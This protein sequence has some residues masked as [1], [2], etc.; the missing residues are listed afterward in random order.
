MKWVKR[1]LLLLSSLLLAGI[2][3]LAGAVMFLQEANYKQILAWGAEQFLDSQLIINGPLKLDISRNLALAAGEILF[4]ANDDSYRLAIGKLYINFRLGSYL[5]TRSFVFNNLE[6]KDISL[7]VKETPGD[8]DFDFED[9]QIP[10]VVISQ[11][12]FGNLQFA[13]QEL[14][15]GTL[16]TFSLDALELKELG[17]KQPVSLRARGL[18]EGRPFELEGAFD[19]VAQVLARQDPVNAEMALSSEYINI[20]VQGTIDEPLEGRGLDLKVEGDILQLR[21]IIEIVWDEIPI[22][23]NVRSSFVVRGDYTAPQLEEIDLHIQREGEVDLKVSGSVADVIHGEG[24]DLQVEGSSSNPEVLSWLLFEQHDRMQTL[25]LSGKLQ[26]NVE[27]LSLLDLDATAETT[28]GVKLQVIGN[29]QL[30][31][32]GYTLTKNDAG[33]TVK[34]SIP[35]TKAA[36]ILD[37]EDLPELGPIS[38][39][40]ALAV[41]RDALGIYR[42]DLNVGSPKQNQ[43]LLKGDVGYLPLVQALDLPELN[44]QTDIRVANLASLG[45]QLG[46]ELPALGPAR[47]RGTLVTHAAKMQLQNAQ[48]KIA[49]EGQLTLNATGLLAVNLRDPGVD[50]LTVAMDVG[51]HAPELARL[52]K[53]FNVELP[54]LGP[55]SLRSKL[56]TEGPELVLQGTRLIVGTERQTI[57]HAT[58][59]L[60]TQLR[61]PSQYR[62]AMDVQ[63]QSNEISQLAKTFDYSLPELGPTRITGW[64]ESKESELHFEDV[65]ILVGA[66][67]QPDL[68]ANGGLITRLKKHATTINV[69]YEVVV[70]PLIAAFT[71]LQPN[72]LGRL[73]GNAVIA[74]LD[75]EWGIENFSIESTNTDLYQLQLSGGYDD[76]E[77]YDKGQLNSSLIVDNPRRLGE[78]FGLN[79]PVLGAFHQQGELNFKN[80]RMQYSG[81]TSLGRTNSVTK[82]LGYAN[83]GKPTFEGSVNIPV[84]HLA[85]FGFGSEVTPVV[86]LPDKQEP[87]SPYVFSR[88]EFDINFLN[89]F[90]FDLAVAIDEV[91]SGELTIDSING[92][93]K[94]H[95]GHLSAPLNLGFEGGRADINLDIKATPEPEFQFSMIADDL[96]LGP[97]MSQFQEQV[98]INGYTNINF[99]LKTK[100]RSPHKLASNLGGE[101]SL[102]LENARIPSRYVKLLS[103]DVFGW[104]LSATTRDK[105][106]NL[107]CVLM[108]F[109]VIQGEVKSAVIVADGPRLSIGGQINL[110]LGEET[111]DI[112]II[113]RQ[114]RRMFTS[115]SSVSISGPMRDPKVQAIPARAAAQQVGSFA[116]LGTGLFIP[117]AVVSSIWSRLGDNDQIGDG[118]DTLIKVGEEVL[119]I[120]KE[121]DAK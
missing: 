65:T 32:E 47:L 68:R 120:V 34:F 63:L 69:N 39:S 66:E 80:D 60:G 89:D 61:D 24:L 77:T 76:L 86:S 5:Q 67:K 57:L 88:D 22:L 96:M 99:E 17:E 3:L 53:Y 26:G 87:E 19:S 107:N 109:D 7:E 48:L 85:D 119:E 25:H 98:P 41:S 83:K 15:P 43:L 112:I 93:L 27:N 78:A 100:G 40:M 113:P 59:M 81:R 33:L 95:N 45:E 13:Y 110:N 28:D 58:G 21:D 74:D 91:E 20:N 108:A 52:G 35:S 121:E 101:I 70:S 29:L 36:N 14:P 106:A 49:S 115:T 94:L 118:C 56:V 104:A 30:Q 6:L 54:A 64:L 97:L 79:L 82:I 50:N 102:G 16:H 51:L 62:I 1:L 2:L 4:Y 114:K 11:A 37:I 9:F 117:V 10:P 103:V 46:V 44:L 75:G 84:L 18:F 73:Q 105:H 31:R 38:G 8:D 12:Q 42:L 55:V 71:D 72:Y 90:D 23:G 116:V 111:L 92:S